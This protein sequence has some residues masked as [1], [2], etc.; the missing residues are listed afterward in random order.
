MFNMR[1]TI[2]AMMLLIAAIALILAILKLNWAVDVANAIRSAGMGLLF[3][4]SSLGVTFALAG[5][6]SNVMPGL[7]RLVGCAA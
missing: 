6:L 1:V 3:G 4:V 2:A 7:R 5:A